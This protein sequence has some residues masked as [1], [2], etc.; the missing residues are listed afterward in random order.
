ML[1][2]SCNYNNDKI[3]WDNIEDKSSLYN[4]SSNVAPD[5]HI[6]EQSK[7]KNTIEKLN[8]N[9]AFRAEYNRSLYP[10]AEVVSEYSITG[11]N[12][13]PSVN[14]TVALDSVAPV[15]GYDTALD[16]YLR[17]PFYP[18]TPEYYTVEYL[19]E[20]C[21]P[22]NFMRKYNEQLYYT[23]CRVENEGYL[24]FFFCAR[25]NWL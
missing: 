19:N 6:K 8:W 4:E 16:L 1:L 13:F 18:D 3:F 17:Y 12:W 10:I 23:A 14:N 22:I 24:F 7:Q 9:Q 5:T 11:E 25:R 2:S 15:I 20:H 21:F